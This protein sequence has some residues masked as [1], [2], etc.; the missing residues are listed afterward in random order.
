MHP[1]RQL[2]NN[3][4]V[5]RHGQSIAN[6]RSLIVSSPGIGLNQYGLTDA[7]VKQVR[8]SL[9]ANLHE[10]CGVTKIYA[11]DFLRTRQTADLVASELN[12]EVE[13]S[14]AL[15][16]RYFGDWEGHSSQHY[17]TVWKAD[18]KDSN[19][20]RWNV[21]SVQSVADR[22]AGFVNPI[23]QTSADK[24]YLLVSHGDPLQIL[25]T[26]F[27]GNHLGAHRQID[28]LRTAEIR[29]LA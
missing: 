7:G 22:L 1:L 15:R 11:S 20:Q 26:Y 16:E 28:P 2:R 18:A 27:A 25:L 6:Q 17:D 10:L 3:F 14:P 29:Q 21:E 12:V 9:Q 8:T 23:D 24:T 19:H 4:Y 13:L 5:M